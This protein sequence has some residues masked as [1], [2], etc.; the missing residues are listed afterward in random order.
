MNHFCTNT[1]NSSGFTIGLWYDFIVAPFSYVNTTCILYAWHLVHTIR[2]NCIQITVII[3]FR[4]NF[5]YFAKVY[6]F[7]FWHYNKKKERKRRS[8]SKTKEILPQV[9]KTECFAIWNVC[10]KN[11]FFYYHYYCY[12][13]FCSCTVPISYITN[14]IFKI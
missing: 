1:N 14:V 8:R 5:K 10:K 9:W 12:Y 4:F 6:G 11:F 2:F 7:M 3:Y 13:P